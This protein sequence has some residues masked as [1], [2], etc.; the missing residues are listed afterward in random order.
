MVN[1]SGTNDAP[2][3]DASLRA[4]RVAAA[5]GAVLALAMVAVGFRYGVIYGILAFVAL[6]VLPLAF[7]FAIEAVRRSG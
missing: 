7:V 3:P 5:I 1:E 4:V 6:P 2:S